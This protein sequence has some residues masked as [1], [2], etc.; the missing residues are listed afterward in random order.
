MQGHRTALQNAGSQKTKHS[1]WKYNSVWKKLINSYEKRHRTVFQNAWSQKNQHFHWKK[2]SV[3]NKTYKSIWKKA[4]EP[5]SKIPEAKKT[6]LSLKKQF[7]FFN[8]Y[9]FICKGTEPS[10]KMPEAKKQNTLLDNTILFEK[11]L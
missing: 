11:S 3:P 10:C 5:S 4:T 6:T 7:F 9:K 1:P 8:S 2:H